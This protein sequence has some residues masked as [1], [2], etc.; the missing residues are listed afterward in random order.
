VSRLVYNAI[1]T[2]E[3]ERTWDDRL[4]SL[5]SSHYRME[6]GPTEAELF[7]G[8]QKENSP[9]TDNINEHPMTAPMEIKVRPLEDQVDYWR[10][11]WIQTYGKLMWLQT[12]AKHQGCKPE[13]IK[14]R[15]Q[16]ELER[17]CREDDQ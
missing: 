9:M 7:H 13:E 1:V 12:W 2:S 10:D 14:A 15:L 3:D 5:H 8:Y 6:W 11:R 4:R 16:N 17:L